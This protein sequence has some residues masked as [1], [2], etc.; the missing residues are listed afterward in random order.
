MT[1][2]IYNSKFP[3]IDREEFLTPFDKM[4]DQIK[5]DTNEATEKLRQPSTKFKE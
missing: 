5:K 4:F 1:K 2:V 3:A